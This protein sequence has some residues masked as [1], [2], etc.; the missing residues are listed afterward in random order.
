MSDSI[1]F[2]STE[3]V[4]TIHDRVIAEFGGEARIRDQGLLESAVAMPAAQFGGEYLHRGVPEKAAAYLFHLCKNHAFVDGNK[5]T[6]L[7][8]AEMFLLLND[9]QLLATNEELERLTLGVAEGTVSKE[10]AAVFFRN[11]AAAR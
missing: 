3:E 7:V 2:L 10:D 4:L 8:A 11:H 5:R 6:A 9:W 1:I